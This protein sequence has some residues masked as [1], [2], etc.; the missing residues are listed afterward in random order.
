MIVDL[1]VVDYGLPCNLVVD[2]EV[3]GQVVEDTVA[4]DTVAEDTVAEDTVVVST[5]AVSTVVGTVAVGIDYEA[6]VVDSF[7]CWI[8]R[9]VVGYVIRQLA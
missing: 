6:V 2:A 5:V 4:E 8:G 3:V 1:V 7:A 9:F